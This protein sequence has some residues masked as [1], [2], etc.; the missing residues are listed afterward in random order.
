MKRAFLA[1]VFAAM[2]GILLGQ[3]SQA[4]A[5]TNG[6]YIAPKFLMSFGNA[7][8]GGYAADKLEIGHYSSFTLGGALA[9]GYDFYPKMNIPLRAEIE[10]GMRGWGSNSWPLKP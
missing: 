2:F 4:N 7:S 5:E 6:F 9:A 1:V 8:T 3:P 10:Y